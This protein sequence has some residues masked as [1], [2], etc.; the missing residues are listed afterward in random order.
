MALG[1]YGG[2]KTAIASWMM[3]SGSVVDSTVAADI[4]TLSQALFNS[5]VRCRE[6]ITTADLTPTSNVC[7]LPTNYA[8]WIRVVEK[9]SIRRPLEHI[10]PDQ[11][12]QRYASRPSGL[13]CHF[14][15][16][17]SSLTVLP[18]SSNDVE[19]TYYQRLAAFSADED[20]DWL[21][22]RYPHIYLC[23]GQMFAAEF[24]K[25]SGEYAKHAQALS[26]YVDFLNGQDSAAQFAN[27]PVQPGG[28]R[29]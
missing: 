2:L 11:A 15:L 17:G 18:L 4:V 10:T 25:D 22:T 23:A 1:T 12:D 29:P 21:L 20:Y 7:T 5:R 27:T 28:L 8:Q 9:A 6:M 19:L 14:M 3:D 13:G 26:A 16:V 24:L